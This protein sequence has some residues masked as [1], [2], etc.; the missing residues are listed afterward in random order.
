MEWMPVI[1]G[2][3]LERINALFRPFVFYETL[4]SGDRRCVCT[5]C[6]REFTVERWP[7]DQDDKWWDFMTAKHNDNVT[8]PLCGR[9]A[10]LKNIGRAKRRTNLTSWENILY[11]WIS[12]EGVECVAC[13][14]RKEYIGS[15]RPAVELMPKARYQFRPG[16]AKMWKKQY[17]YTER[18]SWRMRAHHLKS[19]W[20]HIEPAN[21]SRS[22]AGVR[23]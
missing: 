18:S 11:F 17:A 8:C 21:W 22:C 12:D 6:N 14:G 3:D 15:M 19:T 9:R 7:R 13:Y 16:M 2:K 10:E 1:Q 5:A 20:R 4:R 23:A